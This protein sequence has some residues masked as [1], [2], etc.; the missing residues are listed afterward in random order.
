MEKFK[1]EN[2]IPKRRLGKTGVEVTILGLGGEG[3]LRSYGRDKEAVDL[4]SAALDLGINYMESA[5]AYSGSE[6]Y[7][8]QALKG[9]RDKVFL[10]TKSHARDRKGALAHLE[11]SLSNLKTDHLDLWYV[12]DMRTAEEVEAI[13]APGGALD[14]FKEAKDKGLVKFIGVTG[15]QD[16][17][18]IKKCLDIFDFDVALVPVNPA[19]PQHKCFLEE[20]VP[21]A[22]GKD[23]GIVGMKVYLKGLIEAP[24]KLL[25]N[26]ALTQPIATAAIGCDNIEQMND[27]AEIASTFFN[28]KYKEVQR[29]TDII[30]PYARELMYYKP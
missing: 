2:P 25:F 1:L 4:I 29:L 20:I 7:Y 27:N 22:G 14:A 12:H 11:E 16:P 15:H 13:G 10:A 18:I 28:L 9:R 23:I 6:T 5:R 26:Y 17:L 8:G 21:A 19:E 30:S 3:A 24:K